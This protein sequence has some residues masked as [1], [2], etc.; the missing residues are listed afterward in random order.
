MLYSSLRCL[1]IKVIGRS[2]VVMNIPLAPSDAFRTNFAGARACTNGVTIQRLQSRGCLWI[3]ENAETECG[4]GRETVCPSM[5]RHVCQTAKAVISRAWDLYGMPLS[6]RNQ[7]ILLF[8]R[9]SI[10]LMQLQISFLLSLFA[11]F[12]HPVGQF[13]EWGGKRRALRQGSKAE[14]VCLS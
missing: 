9:L 11:V 10:G 14:S 4:A 2:S 5:Y 1:L 3:T 6:K 7:S 13:I 12:L 8:C